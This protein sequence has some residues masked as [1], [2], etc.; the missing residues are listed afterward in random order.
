MDYPNAENRLGKIKV[1][2]YEVD[3][4]TSKPISD[5]P[6]TDADGNKAS[7]VTNVKDGGDLKAG[8][9]Q[10]RLVPGKTYIIKA[11]NENATPLKA[12][13]PIYSHYYEVVN[14]SQINLMFL[15]SLVI[16]LLVGKII[17]MSIL[18]I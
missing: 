6:A 14:L 11:T 8:E 1:E 4:K 13:A 12:T 15:I 2:A 10:F 18:L 16:R 7:Y 5:E 9:Y 17:L 3:P